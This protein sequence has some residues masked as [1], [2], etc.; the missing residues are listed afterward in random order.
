[1]ITSTSLILSLQKKFLFQFT[2]KHACQASES[3]ERHHTE[4]LKSNKN[5]FRV[6]LGGLQCRPIGEEVQECN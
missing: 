5:H 2:S 1:M 4:I 3:E 6:S